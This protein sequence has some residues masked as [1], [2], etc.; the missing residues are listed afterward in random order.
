MADQPIQTSIDDQPGGATTDRSEVQ[1]PTG[2][3]SEHQTEASSSSTILTKKCANCGTSETDPEKPLKPCSKCQTV[4]YCSRD[5]QK[6]D[7]KVHKKTCASDAQ[8]YAQTADLKPASAPRVPK[9][10]SHRGGLQK[11]QFDT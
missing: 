2:P 10:E 3:A 4:R 1:S 5:C 6:K 7:W 8:I 11:W 9:K